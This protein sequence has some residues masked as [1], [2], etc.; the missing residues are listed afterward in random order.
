ML[1]N[2]INW[3]HNTFLNTKGSLKK[4][5]LNIKN[6]NVE[7]NDHKYYV[8]K[9]R[10]TDIP[11]IINVEKAVYNGETPWNAEAFTTELQPRDDRFYL[12]IR[13]RDQLVGFIGSSLIDKTKDCHISNVAVLPHFQDRGIGYFLITKII[14]KARQLSYKSVSLEVR[15]SNIRAQ[16]V[17]SDLGFKKN[18]IKKNYYDGDHEDA[19]DMILDLDLYETIPNNFGI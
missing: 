7:L 5:C 6:H 19:L 14:E 13:Y 17:Y 2:L 15:I 11:E 3:Y 9:A 12:L 18:G 4:E 8:A 16:R 1:K 10:V